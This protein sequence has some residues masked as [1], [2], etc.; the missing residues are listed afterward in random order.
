MASF[1]EV[2]DSRIKFSSEEDK[3]LLKIVENCL[4]KGKLRFKHVE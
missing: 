2:K 1:K 3:I 4:A